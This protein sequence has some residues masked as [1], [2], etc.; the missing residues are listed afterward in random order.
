LYYL[1]V[2]RTKDE[3]LAKLLESVLNQI[4]VAQAT[5]Q[6]KVDPYERTKKERQDYR[7]GYY[8]RNLVTELELSP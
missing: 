4:L 5:E 8:S 7:N 3:K 6:I 1:F 2:K